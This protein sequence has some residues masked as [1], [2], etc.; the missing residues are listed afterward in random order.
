[1]TY[2][3]YFTNNTSVFWNGYPP[4][5]LG[6]FH[7][8]VITQVRAGFM[9]FCQTDTFAPVVAVNDDDVLV[10]MKLKY[11]EFISKIEDDN[12]ILTVR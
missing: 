3:V 2:A 1:M 4:P 5:R 7:E 6:E 12:D 10:M 8:W 11:T 9:A